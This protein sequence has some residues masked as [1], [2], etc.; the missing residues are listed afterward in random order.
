MKTTVRA[1]SKAGSFE[2]LRRL[3]TRTAQSDRIAEDA[4]RRVADPQPRAQTLVVA[5]FQSSI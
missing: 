4:A 3:H 5:A 2:N 1:E